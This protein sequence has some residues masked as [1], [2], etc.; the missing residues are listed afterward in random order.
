MVAPLAP[1]RKSP[2]HLSDYA[3]AIDGHFPPDATDTA[4]A[5]TPAPEG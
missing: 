3:D 5:P 4:P 2:R 1:P